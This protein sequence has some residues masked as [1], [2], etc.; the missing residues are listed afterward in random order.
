MTS[1]TGTGGA[2]SA[3]PKVPARAWL[4]FVVTYFASFMA[5][6]A[7]FKIPPLASWLFPEFGMD[8]AT[9]GLLMSSLAIIGVILAFPAAFICRRLGLKA[10]MLISVACLCVG[11]FAGYLTHSLYILMASRMLEGI[12][13]GLVGVAAPTCVTIW[14]PEHRRGLALGIWTTWVPVGIILMFNTAPAMANAWGF[15]AVFLAVA[16]LSLIAFILFA[17]VFKLPEG[18]DGDV[19]AGGT[20]TDGLKLL[21]NKNIWLLGIVFFCF[22]GTSLGITNS[23]YNTFLESVRGFTPVDSSF[24]TSLCTLLGIP[25]QIFVGFASDYVR[26]TRRRF[27]AVAMCI[28]MG[29]SFFVMFNTGDAANTFMWTFVV[30]QAIGGGL[31]MGSLRPMAPM[32]MQ[33]GVL[34]ATMGMAVLQLFQNLGSAICPPLFGMAIGV[35]GWNTASLYIQVPLIVVAL[36][37]SFLIIP[38]HLPAQGDAA[39]AAE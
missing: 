5:P 38:K 26:P 21:K 13:I 25:L 24:V 20:F 12:G 35:V 11:S 6:M 7:Q 4:I 23:F 18:E 19:T 36:I 10:V 29:V 27:F 31:A 28:V 1:T 9:F 15:R 37:C 32:L 16:V 22:C 8:P 30:L 3:K 34:G 2:G 33:G 14:F 17:L 39:Q